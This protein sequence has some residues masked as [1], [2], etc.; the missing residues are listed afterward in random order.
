[1]KLS[2]NSAGIWIDLGQMNYHGHGLSWLLNLTCIIINE[3]NSMRTAYCFF[4]RNMCLVT[5]LLLACL[6]SENLT[7]IYI[8]YSLWMVF[9]D[10]R[11]NGP[12]TSYHLPNW[13]NIQNES[14]LIK[15]KALIYY[16]QIYITITN[17]IIMKI[18]L[19]LFIIHEK[20]FVYL[21]F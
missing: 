18:M 11:D 6:L 17:I 16:M 21:A 10:W 9:S 20:T 14:T 7:T 13:Y 19:L 12:T 15:S 2:L 5:F 3:I 4:W 8:K 1:M